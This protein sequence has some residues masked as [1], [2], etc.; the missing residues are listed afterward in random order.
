MA[1]KAN[2]HLIWNFLPLNRIQML[3]PLGLKNTKIDVCKVY[4]IIAF[5]ILHNLC[6]KVTAVIFNTH[7][8]I[9]QSTNI[10]QQQPFNT[11]DKIK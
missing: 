3:Y 10:T 2:K 8:Y 7:L 1:T 6:F 9:K 11:N 4:A 5:C